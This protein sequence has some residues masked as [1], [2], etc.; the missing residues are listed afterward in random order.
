M[1]GSAPPGA[2]AAGSA[3]GNRD[4]ARD[5]YL[6]GLAAVANHDSPSRSVS[7]IPAE[8]TS[9]YPRTNSPPTPAF[10][11]PGCRRRSDRSP[12]ARFHPVPSGL[13][14]LCLPPSP[15]LSGTARMQHTWAR[16]SLS[17]GTSSPSSYRQVGTA[18]RHHRRIRLHALNPARRVGTAFGLAPPYTARP[19]PLHYK[20]ARPPFPP[21]PQRPPPPILPPRC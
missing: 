11:P 19:H 13:T 10:P 12:C 8:A 4:N 17:G 16:A 21:H 1:S 2:W 15:L 20:W 6:M 9:R 3:G 14:V 5:G 7:P 18:P